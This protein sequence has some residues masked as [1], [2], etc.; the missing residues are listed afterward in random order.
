M[1]NTTCMFTYTGLRFG[2]AASTTSTPLNTVTSG[3]TTFVDQTAQQNGVTSPSTTSVPTPLP[4]HSPSVTSSL[5]EQATVTVFSANT[6]E[7][8]DSTVLTTNSSPVR[9]ISDSFF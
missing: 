4:S 9:D 7:T 2:S 3:R 1:V 6:P 5:A 8:K